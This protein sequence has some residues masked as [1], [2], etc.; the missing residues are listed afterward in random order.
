MKRVCILILFFVFFISCA[1]DSNP[2]IPSSDTEYTPDIGYVPVDANFIIFQKPTSF[3]PNLSTLFLYDNNYQEM[4][5]IREDVTNFSRPRES[6]IYSGFTKDY[7]IYASGADLNSQRINVYNITYRTNEILE[8]VYTYRSVYFNNNGKILFVDTSDHR[9]KRMDVDGNNI[10]AIADPEAPYKFGNFWVSFDYKKVILSEWQEIADYQTGHYERLVLLNSDGSS[11]EVLK[12]QYLGEAVDVAWDQYTS[13]FIF[14]YYTFSDSG[15]I[16]KKTP[17][18]TLYEFKL[19]SI[20]ETD[21]TYTDLGGSPANYMIYTENENV[22]SI[23]RNILYD[24]KTGWYLEDRSELD[25]L[26]AIGYW[27]GLDDLGNY[28]MA[29]S[30]GGVIEIVEFD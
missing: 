17:Y 10:I 11:R 8:G 5:I 14:L 30:D 13:M 2:Y 19:F 29:G 25:K 26:Y 12:N 22:Y 28:Y 23:T 3:S 1:T 7:F 4:H 24:G 9:F 16:F 15:A 6:M 20:D 18:Y 27:T 21:L